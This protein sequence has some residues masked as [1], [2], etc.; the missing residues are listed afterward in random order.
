M[1]YVFIIILMVVC[2]FAHSKEG[3]K[4]WKAKTENA[5][6]IHRAI[7]EVTDVMV[8][9]IYSPPVASRTYAYI[10]VAAYEAAINT[11]PKYVSFAGQLH[12][13]TP[14]PKPDAGK[15]YS[16]TLASAYAILTVGRSMV[17]SEDKINGFLDELTKEFK[18]SGMPDDV[19]NN[20]V[21][22]GKKVAAHIL[23]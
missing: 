5:D 9:D 20:S 22:Y 21:D 1:R 2:S 18:D 17:I 19:F 7:K 16:F 11:N 4:D 8:Y 10:T 15:Q 14:V 12:G 6:Y 23:D 3:A 13:L